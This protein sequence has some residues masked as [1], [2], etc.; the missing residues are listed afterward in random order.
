MLGMSMSWWKC[1]IYRYGWF[2]PDQPC[3]ADQ[4]MR[5]SMWTNALEIFQTSLRLATRWIS[6]WVNNVTHVVSRTKTRYLFVLKVVVRTIWFIHMRTCRF[7]Q[8]S[9][10]VS[11]ANIWLY[12][13]TVSHA[14]CIHIGSDSIALIWIYIVLRIVVS[15]EFCS[16]IRSSSLSPHVRSRMLSK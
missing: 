14:T 8:I 13:L 10:C 9:S 2:T 15:H 3:R 1:T 4:W 7:V 12:L 11:W 6:R 5:K 16:D